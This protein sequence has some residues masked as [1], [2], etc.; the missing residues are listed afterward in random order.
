[1]LLYRF[2]ILTDPPNLICRI[3]D[4]DYNRS[5]H[6][7]VREAG[8]L[9]NMLARNCFDLVTI[10]TELNLDF[11]LSKSLSVREAVNSI[12]IRGRQGMVRCSCTA[13]CANNRCS[14]R[15]NGLLC[16]SKCHGGNDLCK[17]I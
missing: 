4:I 8:V 11:N 5:L 13:A 1:M 12:S 9:N 16:N 7:L 15:K 3:V 14:C 10:D 17:N 2:R 6:E